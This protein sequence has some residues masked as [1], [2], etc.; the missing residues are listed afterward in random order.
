M[1]KFIFLF[2]IILG[3]IFRKNKIVF[4]LIFV[5]ACILFGWNYENR[6]Y[7][8]YVLRYDN[9]DQGLIMSGEIGFSI[10]CR[11]GNYFYLSFEQF[12][13]AIA[14]CCYFIFSHIISKHTKYPAF[15]GALYLLCFF[16]LDVTQIRNFVAF[17]IILF[18][19]TKYLTPVY[20]KRNAILYTFLI[21]AATTIHLTSIFFLS[22]LLIYRDV[23]WKLVLSLV[24]VAAVVQSGLYIFIYNHIGKVLLYDESEISLTASICYSLVQIAN[25][26]FI[27]Y[28]A[29]KHMK[30]NPYRILLISINMLLIVIVPFYWDNSIYARLFRF[31]AL[32]NILYFTDVVFMSHSKKDTCL[33][34]CY[35]LYFLITFIGLDLKSDVITCVFEKN[36][37]L[38]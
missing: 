20:N 35:A 15:V 12:R 2:L 18:A 29:D 21:I 30:N 6:D 19:F 25:Y 28:L 32:I 7:D 10:L 5:F 16:I 4:Y 33:L 22:F 17:I 34:L 23:N 27:K 36:S 38:N 26:Y 11:I 3:L 9:A 31:T 14:I 8:N 1:L 13:A 37:L 24:S